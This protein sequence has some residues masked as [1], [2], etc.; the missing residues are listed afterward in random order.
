MLTAYKR[1]HWFNSDFHSGFV[2]NDNQK[3]SEISFDVN[4]FQINVNNNIKVITYVREATQSKPIQIKLKEPYNQSREVFNDDNEGFPIIY[5]NH[6]GTECMNNYYPYSVARLIP[7]QIPRF[8]FRVDDNYNSLNSRRIEGITPEETLIQATNTNIPITIDSQYQ[9]NYQTPM[10]L[11]KGT[12]SATFSEGTIL[13]DNKTF[14]KPWGTYF[15]EDW[16]GTTLLDSSGNGRHA[17]TSGVTKIVGSGNG[18]TG[19]ITY[20]TGTTTSTITWPSGSI[21]STFTIASLTR[22]NY[23]SNQVRVLQATGINW[24]HGH[25]N[26]YKGATY[27]GNGFKSIGTTTNA[28]N[29]VCTIGKNSGSIPT[30][31]LNDGIPSGVESG[32]NGNSALTINNSTF[33]GSGSRSDFSFSFVMIWDTA[34]TNDQML[35]LNTYVE[36]YKQNV[37]S[38]KDQLWLKIDKSYPILKD[39]NNA[40]INPF[41]WYQLDT[42]NFLLDGSGNGY[43]LTNN[44]TVT[45]NQNDYAKGNGSISL[46][47]TNQYL[48]R[49]SAFNFN[50]KSFS[51]CAWVKKTSNAR[52]DFIFEFGSV[53]GTGLRCFFGYQNNDKLMFAIYGDTSLFSTLAYTDAGI[54]THICCTFETGTK[55]RKVYRNGVQVGSD[56]AGIELNTSDT[57]TLG[58]YLDTPAYF[59]GLID[60][61]RI[62]NFVLTATQVAEL[63]NGRLAIYNPPGFILG[64]EIEPEA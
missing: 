60:D 57:F 18:A 34:L 4:P 26:G 15:A 44:N 46:N 9:I 43:D 1:C 16:S 30:N 33:G 52:G 38:L 41:A 58:A 62:Y 39:A 29:W 6:T 64:T 35:L 5:T 54:W 25:I 59:Q 8:T 12:Y 63:Y 53:S 45:V 61:F 49:T 21:P 2:L 3:I 51:V 47:G 10:V 19:N 17:T 20:L 56:N 13:L 11:P 50:S 7:Q 22:Y 27:Y 55:A 36:K 37:V 40:T 24:L 28:T 31:I 14:P 42:G 23:S 48:Q 32:G